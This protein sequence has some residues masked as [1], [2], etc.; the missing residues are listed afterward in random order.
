MRYNNLSSHL[1]AVFGRR[2]RK[3]SVDAGFTCPNR[4][5][6]KGIGGCIYCNNSAF[7]GKTAKRGLDVVEQVRRAVKEGE[8]V[9]VYFQPFTNTYAEASVLREMYEKVLSI[10]EVVGISIGTRADCIDEE[11]AEILEW[12]NKRTYL[13]IEVGLQSAS[14]KTLKLINRGHTVSDF[15]KAVSELK[16]RGIKV[17]AHVIFGLPDETHEDFINTGRFLV[18][19]EVDGVKFHNI[20]VLKDTEL[21][22]WY[23]EGRFLPITLDEYAR[24]VAEVIG[25]LPENVVIHRVQGDAHPN[26]IVAPEWAKSK[27][28]IIKAVQK[29][30]EE[31]DIW[32][33]KYYSK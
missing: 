5:G 14:D 21:E 2:I 17:C 16:R 22:R 15:E 25:L 10:K 29:A 30:L 6:T 3:V 4:D 24:A 20:Q 13:W 28:E 9:I 27:W 33:G 32:Q 23:Y 31:L 12:L 1:R 11:I 18:K 19:T 26:L 7:T 8:R